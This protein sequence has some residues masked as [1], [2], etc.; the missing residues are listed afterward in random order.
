MFDWREVSGRRGIAATLTVLAGLSILAPLRPA[1]SPETTVGLFLIAGAILE[2]VH[3]Q[4]RPT[5]AERLSAWREGAVTLLMATLLLGAPLLSGNALVIFLAIS[6]L[7]EGVRHL[8]RGLRR[9]GPGR[10]RR[11]TAGALDVVAGLVLLLFLRGNA[12]VV[13]TVAAAG[14]FRLFDAAGRIAA[15]AS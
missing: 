12:A 7:V 3:G 5:A 8:A 11:L 2:W 10:P 4:R 1:A 6:F 13:W 15:P 9:R 14:A